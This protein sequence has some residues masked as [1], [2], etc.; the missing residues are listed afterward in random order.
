MHPLEGTL[1]AGE[2]TCA[3]NPP[4]AKGDAHQHPALGKHPRG[5]WEKAKTKDAEAGSG[6]FGTFS[7][8]EA[9]WSSP[10]CC[11][12][13]YSVPGKCSFKE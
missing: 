13:A 5:H 8:H 12:P 1:D 3:I 9:R 10:G 7:H 4:V 6:R 2:K 11:F